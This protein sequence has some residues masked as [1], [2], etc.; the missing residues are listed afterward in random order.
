[1][2]VTNVPLAKRK[3]FVV[4]ILLHEDYLISIIFSNEVLLAEF[5]SLILVCILYTPP[6]NPVS[7]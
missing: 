4:L 7:V 6:G 2:A 3:N 5:L 1:M